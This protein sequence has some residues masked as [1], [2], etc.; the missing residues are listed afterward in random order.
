MDISDS[1]LIRQT[2]DGD[3]DAFGH[4][5]DRYKD[6]VYG[7]A[8]ARLGNFQ[9]AQDIA[10]DA[11]IRAYRRLASLKSP[12]RFAGWLYAIACR[13]CQDHRRARR[14]I[15][16]PDD[17]AST[18]PHDP[19]EEHDR[20]ALHRRIQRAVAALSE[21]HRETVTLYYINGYTSG[22]VG[23]FLNVPVGTVKRRL[24]DA[25]KQLKK[26]MIDMVRDMF[27]ANR[28]PSGFR[29]VVIEGVYADD[30]SDKRRLY[31]RD[32]KKRRMPIEISDFQSTWVSLHLAHRSTPR[33]LTCDLFHKTCAAFG[34]ALDG[35]GITKHRNRYRA[36]ATF[37][38][39]RQSV[40]LDAD[41]G[42]AAALA[43]WF[44]APMYVD[45]GLLEGASAP[46][47]G[48][49]YEPGQRSQKMTRREL[50][51][52]LY[53]VKVD[54]N[55]PWAYVE[56]EGGKIEKATVV[57]SVRS[58]PQ[59]PGKPPSDRTRARRLR[60]PE[61]LVPLHL[62]S[63]DRQPRFEKSPMLWLADADRSARLPIVM[64]SYE[65]NA[66]A[67][68]V[69]KAVLKNPSKTDRNRVYAHDLLKAVLDAFGIVHERAVIDLLH[70]AIFY[71]FSFFRR[72]KTVKHLDT[73]PSDAIALAVRTGAVLQ[74]HREIL[75]RVSS[76]REQDIKPQ[77]RAEQGVY[78]AAVEKV[79]HA[80]G[81]L[82]GSKLRYAVASRRKFV[83]ES[84]HPEIASVTPDGI[85]ACHKEGDA[86]LSA[87]WVGRKKET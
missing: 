73:R 6:A 60:D 86:A 54:E 47:E 34:I 9:D 58:Q 59:P 65:T 57:L 45:D 84:S 61:A 68:A 27:D 5:V 17:G 74:V 20:R 7:A 51:Q 15:L 23:Q 83:W 53:T 29:K 69:P 66:I 39:G 75:E 67:A 40:T 43:M 32:T 41:A 33:P 28:L 81:L 19:S 21:I 87:T 18:I 62:I 13:L 26:E 3:T 55:A 12:D 4:L 70:H 63:I 8:Y 11:F 35:I 16:L 72:G 77:A 71:A 2:L 30:G 22:E 31:L 80:Y 44:D 24:S 49:P 50:G 79:K 38:R 37:S 82:V 64:G 1:D 76:I 25:R 48:T 85:V 78:P 46:P 42:D 14:E 52:K 56:S 36:D 10:Q